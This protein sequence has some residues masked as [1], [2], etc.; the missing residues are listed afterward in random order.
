METYRWETSTKCTPGYTR[1]CGPGDTTGTVVYAVCR[2]WSIARRPSPKKWLTPCFCQHNV[3]A[4]SRTGGRGLGNME[5]GCLIWL[6]AD[7]QIGKRANSWQLRRGDSAV[8]PHHYATSRPKLAFMQPA[9]KS[10]HD[11]AKKPQENMERMEIRLCLCHHQC[12]YI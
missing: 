6:H 9:P 12:Y 3:S 5:R 8:F 7:L 11:I 2:A 1:F 10:L 4:K